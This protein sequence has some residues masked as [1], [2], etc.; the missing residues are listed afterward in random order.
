MTKRAWAA[1]AVLAALVVVMVVV[2]VK[3]LPSH[4]HSAAKSE[5]STSDNQLSPP[6][7]PATNTP[8]QQQTS[9]DSGNSV[10]SGDDITAA[11]QVMVSYLQSLGS[12]TYTDRQTSWQKAA[13]AYTTNSGPIKDFTKLPSGKS[14]AECVHAKCSSQSTAS[15]EHDTA[16]TNVAGSGGGPQVVSYADLSTQLSGKGLS[17]STQQ[18]QFTI[19]ATEIG[20]SW[21]VSGCT[22]AGVGDQGVNGDGP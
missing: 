21:K 18:T 1:L 6:P 4:H 13:L 22:F 9:A 10:L 5:P 17:S 2:A 8:E 15:I 19:T 3:V 12:Y 16:T 11:H 20:D 14:W 7:P